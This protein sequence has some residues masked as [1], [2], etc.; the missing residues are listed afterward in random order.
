MRRVLT[1]APLDLV[2]LLL[3]L[4][5]FQ[6]IELGLMRLELG[7]KLVLASFFLEKG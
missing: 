1:P 7:V 6:V 3:D 5:T 2:D 4:Q